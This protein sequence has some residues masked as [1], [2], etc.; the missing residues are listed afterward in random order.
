MFCAGMDTARQVSKE[1]S[2]PFWAIL[3]LTTHGP[4]RKLTEG[5]LAWQANL[6]L[7]HGASG[8]V[9]FTYWTPNPSEGLGYRDGPIA[10]DGTRNPSYDFVARLNPAIEALGRELSPLRLVDVFHTGRL[11]LGGRAL[12]PTSWLQVRRG[13]DLTLGFFEGRSA[14]YALLV[15]R[16]YRAP[17]QVL[18]I[19][20]GQVERFAPST[21][22]YHRVPA[23]GGMVSL[24][25]DP[26]GAALI[27]VSKQ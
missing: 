23:P 5:E 9:W 18:V 27:R 7:A 17:Q 8:I 14:R 16:D 2:T 25:L 4:F 19:C 10:Y 21:R 12:P 11:P 6:A 24:A 1:T 22:S 20:L 3:L 15:N 26:G 13:G